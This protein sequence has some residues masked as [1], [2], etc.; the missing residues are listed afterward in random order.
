LPPNPP[1]RKEGGPAKAL[2]R[3]DTGRRR[4]EL[5]E[6]CERKH[7]A[8]A[9]AGG[10]EENS[11]W[12]S[13]SGHAGVIAKSEAARTPPD[14]RHSKRRIPEGCGIVHRTGGGMPP[15]PSG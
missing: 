12:S 13:A 1:R 8:P 5:K 11:R 10:V 2:R 9:F 15:H 4:G 7:A 6:R 14:R 3:P